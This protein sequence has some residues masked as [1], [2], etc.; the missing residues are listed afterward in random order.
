M[1]L[2]TWCNGPIPSTLGVGRRRGE[3]EEGKNKTELL[4]SDLLAH[5]ER[6]YQDL[7]SQA[8]LE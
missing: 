8:V 3:G 1:Y 7:E 2:S 6:M 5:L 4:L